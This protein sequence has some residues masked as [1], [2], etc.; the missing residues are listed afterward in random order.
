MLYAPVK[1]DEEHTAGGELKALMTQTPSAVTE[2]PNPTSTDQTGNTAGQD[3]EDGVTD[4]A[5]LDSL[6][7]MPAAEHPEQLLQ[8]LGGSVMVCGTTAFLLALTYVITLG[9]LGLSP[10]IDLACRI[11]MNSC[12]AVALSC[13]ALLIF[14][15]PGTVK[16]SV[17]TC[18]PLPLSVREHLLTKP[19]ESLE[20]LSNSQYEDSDDEEATATRKHSFCVR[21]CVW[22]PRHAHHCRTCQRCVVHFGNSVLARLMSNNICGARS[23]LRRIW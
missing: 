3:I 5:L 7:P 10:K 17:Q 21:C 9:R 4:A 13:L 6:P 11:A 19:G 8:M 23:P 15:D 22:R 12:A 20:G 18:L 14:G 16:R 1:A 2:D